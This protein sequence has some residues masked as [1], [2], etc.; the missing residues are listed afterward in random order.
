MASFNYNFHESFIFFFVSDRCLF[1]HFSLQYLNPNGD[2][3]SEIVKKKERNSGSSSEMTKTCKSTV[4]SQQ[5]VLT[6][7]AAYAGLRLYASENQS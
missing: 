7:S 5:K 4:I 3:R 6:L 2:F 1:V